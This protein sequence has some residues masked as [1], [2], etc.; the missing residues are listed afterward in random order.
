[1]GRI[2]MR[3]RYGHFTGT[4]Y[5]DM[6][7]TKTEPRYLQVR[8]ALEADIQSGKYAVGELMPKEEVLAATYEV[9]RHTIREAMRGLVA[10]GMVERFAR[11]GSF[12]KASQPVEKHQKFVA[13]VA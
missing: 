10:A 12:V 9:S 3:T 1:S 11:R 8:S 13:G 6:T 2:C 5:R 7:S 4:I